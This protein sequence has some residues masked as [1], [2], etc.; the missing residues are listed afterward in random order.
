MKRERKLHL[1]PSINGGFSSLNFA[2]IAMMQILCRNH[3][4][5]Q[6]LTHYSETLMLHVFSIRVAM[7]SLMIYTMYRIE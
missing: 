3:Q 6:S 1:K 4:I 7:F 2:P 5:M